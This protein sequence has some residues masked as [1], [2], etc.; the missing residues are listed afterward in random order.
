MLS[1]LFFKEHT[2]GAV[3]LHLPCSNHVSCSSLAA[4]YISPVSGQVECSWLLFC[5]YEY[6]HLSSTLSI[7]GFIWQSTHEVLW[8]CVLHNAE[9]YFLWGMS[10]VT[11]V[12]ECFFYQTMHRK[13]YANMCTQLYVTAKLWLQSQAWGTFVKLCLQMCTVKGFCFCR[14]EF[15]FTYVWTQ[16]Q[17]VLSL[18]V[19]QKCE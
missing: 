19:L 12:L 2:V 16:W 13:D 4:W 5:L 10:C 3:P 1:W 7:K 6:Y 18:V 14:V 15:M 17:N 8:K 11:A 9:W